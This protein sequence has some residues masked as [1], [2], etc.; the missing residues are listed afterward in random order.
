MTSWIYAVIYKGSAQVPGLPSQCLQP[1]NRC[2]KR[3]E[4]MVEL[5][6]KAQEAF[7]KESTAFYKPRR[8]TIVST[9]PSLRQNLAA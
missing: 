9:L 6:H 8:L 2:G 5:W 3:G 7:N 4:C 1:H